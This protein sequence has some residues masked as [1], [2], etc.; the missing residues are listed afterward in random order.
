MKKTFHFLISLLFS[1][2][3][4]QTQAAESFV[5]FNNQGWCLNEGGCVAIFVDTADKGVQRAANNLC[6]DINRVCGAQATIT[7]QRDEAQI[8]IDIDAKMK[9]REKYIIDIQNRRV[10]ITG[11]DKRGAIYGIYKFRFICDRNL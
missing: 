3:A 2:F 6:T 1:C 7:V 5:N 9:A 4:A 10:N 11:S 8:I